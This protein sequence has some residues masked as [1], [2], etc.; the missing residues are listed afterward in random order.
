MK[1][2]NLKVLL[3]ILLVI[4]I[5]ALLLFVIQLISKKST[6]I[7]LDSEIQKEIDELFEHN[8]CTEDVYN[9]ND[10]ST[11]EQAQETFELCGGT[12]NDVHGLDGDN[13]GVVCV[14][15]G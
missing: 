8:I 13:D 10:F 4:F 9:C 14:S 11:Q 2:K 3:I 5:L 15:L 1:K 6:V 7:D 12:N